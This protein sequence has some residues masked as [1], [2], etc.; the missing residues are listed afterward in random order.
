METLTKDIRY[1][2]RSS[3]RYPAFTLIAVV[4]LALGIGA[5][6]AIFSV[7]NA[8]L[9][10][11]LPFTEPDKLMQVWEVSIK[12]DKRRDVSY[13]NFADWRDQNQSFQQIAAYSDRTFNLT[14]DVEPER[15]Q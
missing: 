6:T 1:A 11:S 2:I 7:V 13:P 12:Q 15:I 14:G 9:L 5:N 10:R 3:I 4:T 8:L